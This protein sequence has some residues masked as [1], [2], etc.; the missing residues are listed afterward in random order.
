MTSSGQPRLLVGSPIFPAPGEMRTVSSRDDLDQALDDLAAH[1]DRWAGSSAEMRRDMV[2]QIRR[3]VI[4]IG[5]PWVSESLQHKGLRHGAFAESEEWILYSVGLRLLRV[6]DRSLRQTVEHGRP[7]LPGSPRRNS[8]GRTVVP[9]LPLEWHDRIALRGISL[10][11]WMNP[12]VEP[13]DVVRLQG[14]GYLDEQEVGRTCLVLGAG[15]VGALVLGD[16]L[17]KL[18]VERR[19]VVLKLNPLNDYLGPLF[20]SAFVSAIDTGVLRIVY[21]GADTGQYLV[22]HDLV[23]E[24]HMTGSDK[25]YEAIVFGSDAEAAARKASGTPLL[26]KPVTA[27]LGSV[28]PVIVLPG[29]WSDEELNLW[30]GRIASW[31][32]YNAGFVCVAPRVIITHEAWPQRERLLDRIG[33]YLSRV[34]PRHAYYPGAASRHDAFLKEHPEALRFGTD[35]DDMLPWTLVRGVDPESEGD[36]VF[37][38]EAFCSLIAET[39]LP[40]VD[41][42]EFLARAVDFAND[43]LWGTLAATIIASDEQMDEMRP[44]LEQA[45]DRLHYGAVVFNFFSGLGYAFGQ[46]PIG[47]FPGSNITD[48]QS[49]TGAVHN[50]LLLTETEKAVLYAPFFVPRDPTI[51]T[52]N[53]VD[54]GRKLARFEARP[55]VA[56]IAA[57][58]WAAQRSSF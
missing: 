1:R 21:G 47:A 45:V 16:T 31:L 49:G 30:A 8:V 39:A 9:V 3:G 12:G 51:A 11:V 42:G 14:A 52:T 4:G 48:I 36:V 5:K 25:T 24:I 50:Y 44:E 20:E 13:E 33:S 37:T 6:L 23:D 2:R 17:S 7:V 35:G 29:D 53:R 58:G 27:E 18:I 43:S 46:I 54:F 19:A 56:R 57:L 26:D 40:A 32:V 41:P 15:N 38:S 28:S 22:N 34:P 10:E 55:S